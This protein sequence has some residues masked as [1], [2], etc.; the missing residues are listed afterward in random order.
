MAQPIQAQ[1]NSPNQTGWGQSLGTPVPKTSNEAKKYRI[2]A[3]ENDEITQ[4]EAKMKDNQCKRLVQRLFG[5]KRPRVRI[6][7]LRHDLVQS[8]TG[9]HRFFLFWAELS[10]VYS[11]HG[12]NLGEMG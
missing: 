6:P 7:P 9:L 10:T 2:S 8:S 12:G 3:S 5:T 1:K 4:F 11:T